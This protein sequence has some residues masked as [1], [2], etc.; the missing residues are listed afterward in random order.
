MH[1]PKHTLVF[2]SLVFLSLGL[3]SFAF[4]INGIKITAGLAVHFPSFRSLFFETEKKDISKVLEN[5]AAIDTSFVIGDTTA[6]HGG[7]PKDTSA[8]L[9]TWIQARNKQVLSNFFD[10]L[11][12]LQANP[13]AIHVLHYGD[14]QIEGDRIT[15]YLRLKFQGQFGGS[16]PGLISLTP[17]APGVINKI[18]NSAGWDRY[19]VFTL[20][21]KRVNHSNFGALGGFSRFQEYKR[22]GDTNS[23]VSS[24]LIVTTTKLGGSNAM[25]YKKIKMFY[26][27]AMSK[28][29]A[30][31]YDGPALVSADS[32]DA[33]GFFRVKEYH[34]T[35]GSN[36]HVFKFSGK[37]SPD[38]Y[39]MS[40]ES[41]HGI[42]VD[43]IGL[44]GSSGT[45]F[46][47]INQNQ[48]KQFYDYLNVKLIILQFGGNALPAITDA[49]LAVNYAGYLRG[50]INILK[51]LAPNA[52]ILFIGPS[53]MSI[54]QG[55][56]YV[57]YPYLEEMRDA[58]KKVVIE[59][60]CA[61][62]DM[63]D[64]M[65]GKNSMPGWVDQKLAATDYIHFS[66]QGA[67][68]MA[69]FLYAALINDYNRYL[70]SK[71]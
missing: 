56:S 30:E 3:L 57:T 54:K 33:G 37:D 50:Q 49:T 67:R 25:A 27:G 7:H 15:D 58:I 70:K 53:D 69:T 63:Y 1:Q 16:G 62:F 42:I 51:K 38:F 68:K 59:S 52:S 34:V 36:T 26:G 65:G 9:I 43:N 19:T 8:K 24:S 6:Q 5:I 40:L 29:W 28:T 55:T 60:D 4:P 12:G 17:V 41:D 48:L 18:S 13:K 66:P 20:K 14:S 61:F 31:F 10:A 39:G 32:L 22:G 11:V 44:R 64:C 23:V 46:H 45:F 35:P 47:M 71:N 2:G 21:D